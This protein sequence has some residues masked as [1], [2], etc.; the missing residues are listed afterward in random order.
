MGYIALRGVK[1]FGRIGVTIEERQ[2][3]REFL[4]EVRVKYNLKKAGHSDLVIDT[5]DYSLIAEAIQT[6]FRKEYH[7]IET[8]CRAIADEILQREPALEQIKIRIQKLS[9]FLVGNVESSEIEWI[10]PEDW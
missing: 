5:F 7:L 9:P 3:G 1:V 8:A 10:Y 6:Q 4:I 2:I